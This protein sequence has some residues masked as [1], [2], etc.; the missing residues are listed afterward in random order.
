MNEEMDSQVAESAA[1]EVVTNEQQA[2]KE[3]D[4]H[5][6]TQTD[7]ET[8][9]TT[10]ESSGTPTS[11]DVEAETQKQLDNAQADLIAA[12]KGQ[13]LVQREDPPKQ[14]EPLQQQATAPTPTPA[15]PKEPEATKK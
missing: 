2:E 12:N 11:T 8:A 6:T 3:I 7:E 1:A 4:D 5:S 14:A 10:I 13:K 15:P 9:D